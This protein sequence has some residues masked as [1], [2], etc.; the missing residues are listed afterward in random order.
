M[1]STSACGTRR[2]PSARTSPA[3][4]PTRW[5][6]AP[7]TRPRQRSRGCRRRSRGRPRRCR[8]PPRAGGAADAIARAD[9]VDSSWDRLEALRARGIAAL[10]A[11]EPAAAVAA[12]R[13][14]WEY[15]A[16]EGVTEPGVFPAGPTLVEALLE[17]DD[18]E[19]ARTV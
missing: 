7:A 12:L 11:R 5:P 17:C 2:S 4:A 6:S 8:L 9:R 16:R 13:A 15:T 19:A 1:R 10:L 3:C 14:V 18:A